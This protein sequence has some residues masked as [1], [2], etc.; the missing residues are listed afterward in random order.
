MKIDSFISSIPLD[1]ADRAAQTTTARSGNASSSLS[2][3]REDQAQLSAGV[4]GDRVTL[5]SSQALRSPE[6][7]NQRVSELAAAV[8]D[9]RYQVSS[10]QIAGALF[11]QLRQ[12][13]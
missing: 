2:G 10:E 3:V 1:G 13:A 8:Q 11:G 6:V 5:L 7:R 9:G 12:H 4:G